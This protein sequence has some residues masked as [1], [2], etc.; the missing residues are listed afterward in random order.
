MIRKPP[1]TCS[2]TT[3]IDRLPQGNESCR[4]ATQVGLLHTPADSVPS[5]HPHEVHTVT[6]P[7]APSQPPNWYPFSPPP[8]SGGFPRMAVRVNAKPPPTF[9]R[10]RISIRSIFL[11]VSEICRWNNT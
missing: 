3:Q 4:T 6:P 1:R 9:S 7:L 2:A 10:K 11:T 8:T 5:T